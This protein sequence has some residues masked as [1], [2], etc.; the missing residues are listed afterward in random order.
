ML[1]WSGRIL[2]VFALV[3]GSGSA[4]LGALRV[5]DAAPPLAI[6]EWINGEAVDPSKGGRDTVFVIEFWATWCGPCR[7]SM[8][9]LTEM[10]HYFGA[11]KLRV[12]A[13]TNEDPALVRRYVSAQGSKMGYTVAVDRE[14]ST[15]KNYLVAAG[16][17][18]IPHAFIV[19]GGKIVGQGNPL[20]DLDR[21]IAQATGDANWVNVVAKSKA[22]QQQL[23]L[24]ERR[25]MMA[26]AQE[27]WDEVISVADEMISLDPADPRPAFHKYLV[28]RVKKQD[29]KGAEQVGRG[30]LETLNDATALG[31][32]A[33][34]IL[35]E[36]IFKG[37]RDVPL[38]MACAQKATKLTGGRNASVLDTLARAYFDSG[39][40]IQAI[41]IQTKAVE[42]CDD[43]QMKRV[44]Q[45]NL[46]RYQQ[47]HGAPKTTQ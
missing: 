11:T 16:V 40:V 25:L 20:V 9:H 22:R 46:A 15:T 4:A 36:E 6:R 13:V 34:S 14:G 38:A 26:Q 17:E 21:Q 29:A 33:W 42:L 1:H 30:I 2:I 47:S 3:V 19:K 24:L 35:D 37:N 18:G 31:D 7:L 45:A 44:L 12:I 39:D 10:Q 32:F 43:A 23:H 27:R 41:S 28:L 5:G 8:P